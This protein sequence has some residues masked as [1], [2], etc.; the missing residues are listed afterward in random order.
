M[1]VED[2]GGVVRSLTME[3][4][5]GEE[6]FEVLIDRKCEANKHT[7]FASVKQMFTTR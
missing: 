3:Y 7:S 2:V 5:H 4:Y 1:S 6:Y